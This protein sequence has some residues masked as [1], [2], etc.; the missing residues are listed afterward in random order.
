MPMIVDINE[1]L[2]QLGLSDRCTETERALVQTCIRTATGAVVRHLKYDP[3]HQTH[4]VYHPQNDFRREGRQAIW[5]VNDTE[6]YVRYLSEYVSNELQLQH[7]PIRSVISVN[8][9]YD[10]RSGTRPGSFGAST[11]KVEGSDYWP[12]YDGTDSAGNKICRDGI[13]RSMGVWPDLAGSVKVVYVAGYTD[14]ELHGQDTVID[15]SPIVES[16][17]D[18]SVRRMLKI[19]SRKKNRLAGF[20]GPLTSESLGDYSYSTDAA[21]LGRL[22]G[23]GMDLLP[24][25]EQKL[26]DFCRYDMGIM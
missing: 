2:I 23:G 12:N 25:T 8:I 24:E 16:V 5:E 14:Q 19:N 21:I 22:I 9:D 26:N 15:A 1:V 11:L 10:G 13:L 6:A 7:I 20:V 4:T 18:E 17:I 3:T